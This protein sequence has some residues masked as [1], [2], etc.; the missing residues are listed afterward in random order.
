MKI[1]LVGGT[2]LVSQYLMPL[3][4]EIGTVITA[5]RK[6]CDLFVDLSDSSKSLIM[7]KGIDVLIHTA[8]QFGGNSFE[9][10]DTTLAVNTQGTLRLCEAA[11]QSGVKH[12]LLISSI[13]SHL[14][15]S[16]PFYNIYS[17]SKK[18]GEEVA[19]F[20]CKIKS[21][22]LTIL[23]PSQIYG[24][25]SHFRA[26]HPFFYSVIDQAQKGEIISFYGSHDALRNFIHIEDLSKIILKCIA[27]GVTG[28]FDCA[29]PQNISYSEIAKAAIAAFK[30]Q[31][32]IQF[33]KEK[34]SIVDNI[35][36]SNDT[37]YERLGFWP[38][39]GILEGMVNIA[40]HRN[41]EILTKAQSR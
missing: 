36:K 28:E 13:F 8:A 10:I 12:F 14:E 16:S 11:H 39:I 24:N 17:I 2:S 20:Y 38:Q 37:L 6:N 35:F 15:S 33:L 7:P 18:Q 23:R 29:H 21:I 27:K 9:E 3:L 22:P 4:T 34:P 5:G 26:H 40:K 41:S 31:S 19:K 1:L 32:E 30:S 25:D